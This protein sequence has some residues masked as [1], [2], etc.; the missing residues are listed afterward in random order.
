MEM[1]LSVCSSRFRTAHPHQTNPR[2]S[3]LH[4]FGVGPVALVFTRDL[5][6]VEET[7]PSDDHSW[8]SED[9]ISFEEEFSDDQEWG[10][11]SEGD[12]WS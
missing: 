12:E 3:I 5:I 11:E 10:E 6:P 8:L 7:F 1:I 4:V 9:E 2:S